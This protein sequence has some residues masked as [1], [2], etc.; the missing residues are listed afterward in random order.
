MYY[1]KLTTLKFN[2][3]F[4]F[5][6]NL[7]VPY[8]PFG[9]C[10]ISSSRGIGTNQKSP[11]FEVAVISETAPIS[12]YCVL[13]EKRAWN[14]KRGFKKQ[15]RGICHVKLLSLAVDWLRTLFARLDR[16]YAAL[17]VY[18]I[19]WHSHEPSSLIYGRP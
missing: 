5:S 17:Y 14:R 13:I 4:T 19:A 10:R 11:L 1:Q 8:F 15:H 2:T 3:L 9:A 18:R 7:S 12:N 16:Q 6:T